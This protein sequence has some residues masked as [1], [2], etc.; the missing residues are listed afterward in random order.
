MLM[1]ERLSHKI[2][3]A[4]LPALL[5]P[6]FTAC[7]DDG[8]GLETAGQF[9]GRLRFCVSTE[10]KW[11][12]GGS[13]TRGQYLNNPEEGIGVFGYNFKTWTE[14]SSSTLF[15]NDQLIGFDV[16]WMTSN[17][18][19][20]PSTNSENR[21]LRFFAYYPYADDPTQLGIQFNTTVKEPEEEGDD[22]ILSIVGAPVFTYEV[23]ADIDL[24][25]DL[26]VGQ[27]DSIRLASNAIEWDTYSMK[28]NHLLTA[29]RVKVGSEVIN[30]QVTKIR[31]KNIKY[32]G[33]YEYDPENKVEVPDGDNIKWDDT[34]EDASQMRNFEQSVGFTIE[35][36]STEYITDE[37][38]TFMM[39]PQV[40]NQTATLE[41]EFN[42]GQKHLLYAVI[43]GTKDNPNFD[44]TQE[45][46]PTN[47]KTINREWKRAKVVTYAVNIKTLQKITVTTSITN[48]NLSGNSVEGSVSD[49]ATI[50]TTTDIDDWVEGHSI[51]VED[52]D[53]T[54]PEAQ[55]N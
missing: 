11:T 13:E 12:D 47:P 8:E 34:Y 27:T 23:P 50:T 19:M 7:T 51:V 16:D 25:T 38:Q 53:A 9:D 48:W 44:S 28:L 20:L 46:S 21:T 45:D 49:A 52:V 36:G 41:I 43:G 22:P 3:V 2:C 29:V 26:M 42:D 40:L 4:A 15:Y 18:Y 30:G 35:E 14:N 39:M 1:F 17:S 54:Q 10:G 37:T 55:G 31:L 6:A 5:F 24:Q 33:R 32:K